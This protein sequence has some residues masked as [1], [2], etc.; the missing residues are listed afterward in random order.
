MQYLLHDLLRLPLED[1]LALIEKV[2]SGFAGEDYSRTLIQMIND[3]IRR[4][5][6]ES[7]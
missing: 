6:N 3:R 5:G 7:R 4:A 2:I 1:R